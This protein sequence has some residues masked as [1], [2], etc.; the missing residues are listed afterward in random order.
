MD[1]RGKHPNAVAHYFK[2]GQSGN[3]GG[4]PAGVVY[5]VEH[6]RSMGGMSQIELEKI[7]DDISQPVNRRAAAIMVLQMVSGSPSDQRQAFA[8]VADRTSGKAIQAVQV[9]TRAHRDAAQVLTE[10]RQRLPKRRGLTAAA[11]KQVQAQDAV[12]T[13]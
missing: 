2:P 5:P 10:L 4:R 8:E 12:H 11:I 3:P 9:E 7:R 13:Q 6:L 1:G